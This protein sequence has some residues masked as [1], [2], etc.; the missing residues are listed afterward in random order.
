MKK[1]IEKP[2]IIG[3]LA[4]IAN[5]VTTPVQEVMPIKKEKLVEEK[6]F[7]INAW[8]PVE[9][10][11]KVKAYCAE[12]DISIKEFVYRAVNQLLEN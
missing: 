3:S 12:H 11:K 1:Q 4:G 7:H 10:K 5:K 8:L 9:Y 2:D 6:G